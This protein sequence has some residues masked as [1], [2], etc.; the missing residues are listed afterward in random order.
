[1]KEVPEK[2]FTNALATF[3][4]VRL[5]YP[6]QEQDAEVTRIAL[7]SVVAE[8]IASYEADVCDGYQ[9]GLDA[10]EHG[11]DDDVTEGVPWFVKG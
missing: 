3:R 5:G 9:R 4:L 2:I 7:R 1:M 10:C 8:A 11:T 6:G